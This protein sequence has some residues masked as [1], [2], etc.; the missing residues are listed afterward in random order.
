[1]NEHI[2]ALIHTLNNRIKSLSFGSEPVEL[3]DP[4]SYIMNLG[5]KRIRPLLAI[6]AYQLYKD[7]LEQITDPVLSLELFHNFTLMH[8]DIMDNAPLRRG[9]PTVHEKWNGNVAILSGDVMMIKVYELLLKLPSELTI[10][11]IKI[12]NNCAVRVCEGQQLDMNFETRDQVDELEYLDMISKKTAALI[13]FSLEFGGFLAGAPA[14]DQKALYHFGMHIGMGFQLTDDL[15]DVYADSGKFGKQTGGD[16][17]ANKKTYLLI[18][19]M[20]LADEKAAS[21]LRRWLKEKEF[22]PTDKVNSVKNIYNQLNIKKLTEEKIKDYF[23]KGYAALDTVGVPKEK[24]A[25]LLNLAHNL[26]NRDQ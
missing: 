15:L 8:D 10:E 11:G 19:A 24:K 26:T 17:I 2:Q 6:L 12:F 16:I 1:M 23:N 9:H 5:G 14:T 21:D 7:D 4:I 25:N 18:K 3:Y 20:E 22:D 13:G